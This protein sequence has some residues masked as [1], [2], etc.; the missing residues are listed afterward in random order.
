MRD[1]IPKDHKK[2]EYCS[3]DKRSFVWIDVTINNICLQSK[4]ISTVWSF[5]VVVKQLKNITE[6][7]AGYLSMAVWDRETSFKNYLNVANFAV[8]KSNNFSSIHV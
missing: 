2:K 8:E 4:S 1:F 5:L 3:F 6:I 7:E